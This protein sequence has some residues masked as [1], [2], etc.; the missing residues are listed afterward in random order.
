MEKLNR[1]FI[2]ILKME[3][4]VTKQQNILEKTTRV[5]SMQGIRRGEIVYIKML[6]LLGGIFCKRSHASHFISTKGCL[7]FHP[8]SFG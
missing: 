6:N 4:A 5:D 2:K 1:F 3:K 7:K 8:L